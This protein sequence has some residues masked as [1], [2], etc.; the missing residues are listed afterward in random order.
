ML[1]GFFYATLFL[2]LL[3][4][5]MLLAQNHETITKTDFIYIG[6]FTCPSFP[7]VFMGLKARYEGEH[8]NES[9]FQGLYDGCGISPQ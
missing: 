8:P 7:K 1:R 4:P 6:A 5:A 9:P 3:T 2:R